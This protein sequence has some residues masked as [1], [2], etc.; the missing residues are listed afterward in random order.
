[1]YLFAFEH[2]WVL[3]AL[4]AELELAKQLASW[5]SSCYVG[6]VMDVAYRHE[7]FGDAAMVSAMVTVGV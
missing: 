3:F 1:M 5:C 7:T 2:G 6:V 4:E